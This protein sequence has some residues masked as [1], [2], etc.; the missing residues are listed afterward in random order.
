MRSNERLTLPTGV[1]HAD[2]APVVS[3][4]ESADRRS[5]LEAAARAMPMDHV[6]TH[7]VSSL[8]VD[9]A[10]YTCARSEQDGRTSVNAHEAPYMRQNSRLEAH[11]S[12]DKRCI[13]SLKTV[14]C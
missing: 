12:L 13:S 2:P 8:N 9:Q 6:R 4:S 14:T 5:A 11:V 1:A 3:T 10:A 7:H